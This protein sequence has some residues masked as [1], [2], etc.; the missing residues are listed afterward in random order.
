MKSLNDNIYEY[1]KQVEKGDIKIA[2]QGI[3][4]FILGL[5]TYLKN[6]YPEHSVSGNVYQGNMD[7]TFFSLSPKSFKEKDLKFAIVFIHEKTMFE[8]WLTGRNSDVQMKYRQL[9]RKTNSEKYSVS[10]D[11]KGISSIIESV[12]V[13]YPNFDNP[14]ELTNIIDNGLISFIEDMEKLLKY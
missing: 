5:R 7:M 1:G 2:Y 13:E 6:K 8:V 4:N 11:E 9:F 14:V 3:M 10:P 12:L